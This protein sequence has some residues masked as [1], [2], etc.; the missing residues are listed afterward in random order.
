MYKKT[1]KG[2]KWSLIG[3]IINLIIQISSGIVLARLISP[4][5][6]GIYA[7]TFAILVISRSII[8]SGLYQALIQKKEADEVDFSLV[9]HFNFIISLIISL[10]LYFFSDPIQNFYNYSQIGILVKFLSIIVLIESFSIIQRASLIKNIR[11]DLITKIET[12]SKLISLSISIIMAYY[13]YGIWS[14][15]CKDLLFS[16]F[17]TLS[18]WLVNP[19]KILF[20]I[21]YNRIKSLFQFGFKV[22]IADQIESMS[23]QMAQIIIGKKFLAADLGFF[24]K[25]EEFQQLFSQVIIVS[26]N[27]VMFP[28]LVQIQED[29]IKL[30]DKY[31]LLL[32]TSMF[33]L[34]PLLFCVILISEEMILFLIGDNWIE[35]VFYFKLLCISGMFYPFTVYNLNIL[36]VKGEG[37]LYL[38]TCLISKGLLI[39]II[40]ISVKFG[41]IGLVFGLIIQRFFAS[42]INSY[43]SGRLISFS[44][45]DQIKSIYKSFIIS[46]LIYVL[47]FSIKSSNLFFISSNL[48][49][50]ISF[51]ILFLLCYYFLNLIFQKQK[52]NLVLELKNSFL[53][54]NR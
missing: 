16:F 14:L 41:I 48:I 12:S 36:K 11:F 24:N 42:L 25:A 44:F 18:Y 21:P 19:V 37:D 20:K 53:N 9:F 26:I 54:K 45:N 1:L 8:D 47:L 17:T 23:N 7:M 35:S 50:I 51:S 4:S 40:L 13:D 49:S 46:L 5:D 15:L 3:T 10:L 38:K 22:F 34:F 28:S 29:N 52:I 30:K 31:K 39:P 6:F 27:K 32:E 43:H 2:L 33:L